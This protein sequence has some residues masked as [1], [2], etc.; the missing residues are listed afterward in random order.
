MKTKF[1]YTGIRVRNLD[2]AIDFFTKFLGMRLRSRI[3]ADWTKGE[4]A[5]LV[6][7]GE[8]HWLELNWYADDSPVA[9]PYK[10]GE[11]L[12][13]LG[14]EVDDFEIMLKKLADAGYQTKIGPTKMGVW[15]V[16]FVQGFENI[17]LDIYHIRRKSKPAKQRRSLATHK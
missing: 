15:E 1:G 17:W 14:F 7:R 2:G 12:D 16:A 11:E 3:K 4:F 6:S 13:H 8:N 10:E 9:S 5:N